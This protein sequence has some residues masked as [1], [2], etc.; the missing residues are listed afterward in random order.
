VRLVL[1]A[2][3]LA[4]SFGAHAG[5][6]I[7]PYIEDSRNQCEYEISRSHPVVV[8][9]TKL[10]S[11]DLPKKILDRLKAFEKKLPQRLK[12]DPQVRQI[13]SSKRSTVAKKHN[14][15]AKTGDVASDDSRFIAFVYAA[16]ACLETDPR[17]IPLRQ[18]DG[19]DSIRANSLRFTLETYAAMQSL[20]LQSIVDSLNVDSNA[21]AELIKLLREKDKFVERVWLN[22]YSYHVKEVGFSNTLTT[23]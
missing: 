12:Y 15:G 3:T 11:P 23:Y 19:C 16:N 10:N 22:Y 21:Q 2:T 13:E 6:Y 1:L 4:M 5:L 9:E 8:A 7:C 20:S 18:T 17:G 14:S